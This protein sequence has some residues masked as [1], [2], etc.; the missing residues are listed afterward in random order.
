[1]TNLSATKTTFNNMSHVFRLDTINYKV[2]KLQ[3]Q[4]T[5]VVRNISDHSD[6]TVK[7][8]KNE[9]KLVSEK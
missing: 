6:I 4:E 9:L 1:M 5:K 8:E 3:V 2:N 7:M